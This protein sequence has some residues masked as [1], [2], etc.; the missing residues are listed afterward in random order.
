MGK[1]T[2]RAIWLDYL[3]AF[4][5][6]LVVAHHSS[7]AY[8]TFASF[9]KQAYNASTHPIVDTA[10]SFGL[11]IFEDFNDV[12][13]MALMFLISG[14]F[15]LP[16]IARKGTRTFVRD[17][18]YRLFIPLLIA[19]T[20][21]MPLAYLSSWHLAHGNYDLH[22]FLVDFITVEH[23]PA[24]PAW[25]IGILFLF[26]LIVAAGYRRSRPSLDNASAGLANLAGK[27]IR[28][29]IG[30]WLLTCCLYL[31]LVLLFG[32]SAWI[33]FGPFAIQLS[34]ILLYFG[35]FLLGML[36]GAAGTNNGLLDE[37][38]AFMQKRPLWVLLC[39]LA[40]N[41]LGLVG[42]SIGALAVNGRISE[43]Q[44]RLLYRS[45]W[46]LS[47]TASSIVFL[48]VFRRRVHRARK[49]WDS[50][51]AN[52]Y[53]IYLIHYLFVLWC[54]FLLLPVALPALVKFALTFTVALL[55]SWLLTAQARKIAIIR[56]WL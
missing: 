15:V 33:G 6:M 51:A 2:D 47:C 25:F 32:A 48:A 27:P 54:Q 55:L 10:R 9:N 44:A 40:Y 28:V 7:L 5:T 14:I 41:G 45:V 4:I 49:I 13:F 37:R 35:Y 42:P 30:W 43:I 12:F 38:S 23:W 1:K 16:A 22:A 19:V 21:L 31:P 3:R 11:D 56:K 53:G 24:G 29:W 20:L 26:N 46:A 50:L 39:V 52:A 18:F 36:L 17:R 34:R 8:T